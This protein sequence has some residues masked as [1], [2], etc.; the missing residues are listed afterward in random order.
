MSYPITSQNT[1]DSYQVC[2]SCKK[3]APHRVFFRKE[4]QKVAVSTY[5]RACD[6]RY[7]K[8]RRKIRIENGEV[9][10]KPVHCDYCGQKTYEKKPF[11]PDCITKSSYIVNLLSRIEENEKRE[12]AIIN[13]GVIDV[14]SDTAKELYWYLVFSGKLHIDRLAQR[15]HLDKG[16]VRRY[17]AAMTTAGIFR[18]SPGGKRNGM[19]VEVV[20]GYQG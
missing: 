18:M 11:C 3:N 16:L 20:N 8:E 7:D 13:G 1:G 2:K 10:A 4:N 9:R 12:N 15:C 6:G 5:C 19:Q 14:N 17:C